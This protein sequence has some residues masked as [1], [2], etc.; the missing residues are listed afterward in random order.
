MSTIVGY[1]INRYIVLVIVLRTKFDLSIKAL[2][3]YYTSRYKPSPPLI[4][5]STI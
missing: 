5:C 3:R 1:S 4:S 2:S